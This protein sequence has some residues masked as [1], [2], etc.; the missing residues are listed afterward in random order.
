M[1]PHKEVTQIISRVYLKQKRHRTKSGERDLLINIISRV[2]KS[3]CRYETLFNCRRSHG[4]NRWNELCTFRVV[5]FSLLTGFLRL[6]I[7]LFMW[8]VRNTT[9]WKNCGLLVEGT[10]Y[11][12]ISALNLGRWHY[13]N[14]DNIHLPGRHGHILQMRYDRVKNNHWDYTLRN[15]FTNKSL[16]G[17][18]D[19]IHLL[20]VSMKLLH[21][22]GLGRY[23]LRKNNLMP[24]SPTYEINFCSNSLAWRNE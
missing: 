6:Y 7:C 10:G 3:F 17:L 5:G 11:Q 23:R 2:N 1:E 20:K 15:A 19:S 22:V 9:S 12:E 18:N 21:M 24:K 13:E 4:E 16:S 14:I 8:C